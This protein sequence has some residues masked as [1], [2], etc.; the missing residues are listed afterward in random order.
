MTLGLAGTCPLA[1]GMSFH[2]SLD[3][4]VIAYAH[5]LLIATVVNVTTNVLAIG[6]GVPW[7]LYRQD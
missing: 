5:A 3:L 7:P 4:L 1:V 6:P 2:H